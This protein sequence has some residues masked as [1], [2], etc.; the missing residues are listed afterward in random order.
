MT[1]RIGRTG[2]ELAFSDIEIRA[3]VYQLENSPEAEID[4]QALSDII[5]AKAE[6][7]GLSTDEMQEVMITLRN[8]V[9]TQIPGV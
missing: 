2:R 3:V 8:A 4:I 9:P 1:E 6:Q 5:A 7:Y